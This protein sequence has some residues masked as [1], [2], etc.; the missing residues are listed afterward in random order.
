MLETRKKNTPSH[1][2][3]IANRAFLGPIHSLCTFVSHR[4]REIEKHQD[5]RKWASHASVFA[6]EIMRERQHLVSPTAARRRRRR[7]RLAAAAAA[8]SCMMMV[9]MMV[10][11]LQSLMDRVW[12]IIFTMDCVKIPPRPPRRHLLLLRMEI[13]C[14]RRSSGWISF[15]VMGFGC[16]YLTCCK[17]KKMKTEGCMDVWIPV[18]I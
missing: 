4:E 9:M 6:Y 12:R 11:E 8:T 3:Q 13:V 2:L 1:K 7:N 18:Y 5:L 14:M 10:Q 17:K 16:M 15:R